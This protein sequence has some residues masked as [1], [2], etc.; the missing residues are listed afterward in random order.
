MY[1][2]IILAISLAALSILGAAGCSNSVSPGQEFTLPAGRSVTVTGENMTVKFA[3]VTSDSRSPKGV[4]TVWAGEAKIQLEI[5]REGVTS[6][7]TVTEIGNTQG[8]T[9]TVYDKYVFSTRLQPYPE[10]D[11]PPKTDEYRLLVK[12]DLANANAGPPPGAG[13][14]PIVDNGAVVKGEVKSV[15]SLS[16][17]RDWALEL[18]VRSVQDLNNLPNMVSGKE[19]QVIVVLTP[20]D[21]GNLT[22]KTVTVTLKLSGDERGTFFYST[23]ITK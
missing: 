17:R 1:R 19:G 22:G 4:Q 14:M 2:N 15:T 6:N 16:S 7:V 9:Q 21:P 3:G 11:K 23:N 8:Y 13:G 10:A 12:I 18:L 5:T 20:E